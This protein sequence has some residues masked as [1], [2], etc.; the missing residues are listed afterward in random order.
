MIFDSLDK[1]PLYEGV[2]HGF[3]DIGKFLAKTDLSQ[4]PVGKHPINDQGA[5]A[6]VNEYLTKT[7]E[8]SFIECHRKYIDVQIIAHGKEKIGVT[9]TRNCSELPYDETKDL[10]KLE[11]TVDFITLLPDFFAV[12]FPHDAHE[13][14]VR[15]DTDAVSV[16]KIVFKIPVS[17]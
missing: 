17:P 14:G 7:V 11:G 9:H 3:S 16:K 1:L 10:Q 4:L 8:E 12:F 6:S 2:A 15:C 5:Y 13:P